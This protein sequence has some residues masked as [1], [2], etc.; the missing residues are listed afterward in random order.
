MAAVQLSKKD[1]Q[2]LCRPERGKRKKAIEEKQ[3]A[4][5]SQLTEDD[6]RFVSLVC[7]QMEIIAPWDG[8]EGEAA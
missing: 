3:A 1:S 5:C 2:W 6:R 4:L 7:V 8:P